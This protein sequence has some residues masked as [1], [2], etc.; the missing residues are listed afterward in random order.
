MRS[1]TAETG[2]RAAQTRTCASRYASTRAAY[3][4]SSCARLAASGRRPSSG[5]RGMR[6]A[7]RQ[8]DPDRD[9][10]EVDRAAILGV[11]ERAAAGGDNEL[12]DRLE[13]AQ[14]LALDRSK[15]RLALLREDLRDRAALA[16]FHQIVDVLGAPA[17]ARGERAGDRA[18]AACHEAHEIDLVRR[19]A[20][21]SARSEANPGYD[22]A[23]AS[24]PS[25]VVGPVA[26]SP[27]SANAMT[28]R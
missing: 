21:S 12:A 22:T 9:A 5:M 11:G 17:E 8:I 14:D 2:T 18:L 1:T 4:C 25:I 26:P 19:H 15:V 20:T 7:E 23:T 28:S 13:N 3:N 27:T 16:R 6:S 24:A 10:V